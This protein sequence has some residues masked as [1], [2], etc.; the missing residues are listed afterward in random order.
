[1]RSIIVY[2][3]I[4]ILLTS[5][6]EEIVPNKVGLEEQAIKN[7]AGKTETIY[8]LK[9]NGYVKRN[10]ADESNNYQN[11]NLKFASQSKTYETSGANELFE[12]NGNWEITGPNYDKIIL[13]GTKP[14]SKIEIS[15]TKLGKEL[16]L[17]FSI[18]TPSGARTN[19]ISG[20]YE[21]KMEQ[22]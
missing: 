14:G 15:F 22:N 7:L 6:K 5:C 18:P 16:V 20:T 17:V 13:S 8:T 9:N 12:S 10:Q 2:S 3:I 11:I 4:F 21:I 1:M 19:A